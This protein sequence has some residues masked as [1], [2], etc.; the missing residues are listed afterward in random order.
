MKFA[1][2]SCAFLWTSVDNGGEQLEKKDC[3]KVR[4]TEELQKIE[5]L[6]V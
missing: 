6:R 2:R 1:L 5:R 4:D 3:H